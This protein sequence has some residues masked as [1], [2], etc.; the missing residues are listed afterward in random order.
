MRAYSPAKNAAPET[1][2][3]RAPPAY[4]EYAA[5]LLAT[6]RVRD[7]SLA[8][9]GLLVGMRWACWANGG[10][11]PREPERIARLLGKDPAEVKAAMTD[12]VLSFFG[13]CPRNPARLH[14]PELSRQ[15]RHL[16]E[17]AVQRTKIG[18]QGANAR[19]RKGNGDASGNAGGNASLSRAELSRENGSIPPNPD[20]DIPF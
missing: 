10:D 5:D 11:I 19:W 1:L 13:P 15:R 20:D 7:M 14:D 2:A 12:A 18:K 3:R 9:L 6:E 8:E 16:L 4:Q 17:R